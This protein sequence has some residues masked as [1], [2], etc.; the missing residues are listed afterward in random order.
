[1]AVAQQ[2]AEV[3]VGADVGL[4]LSWLVLADEAEGSD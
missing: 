3:S 1:L 2:Q 4:V